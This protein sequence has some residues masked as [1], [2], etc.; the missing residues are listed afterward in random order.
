MKDKDIAVLLQKADEL[1]AL[2]TIGQRVIPFI[3]EIFVFVRDI[4]PLLDDINKSVA[5]NIKKMPGASEQLSKVNEANELAT[6][7]IMD[8]VD[9]LLFKVDIIAENVANISGNND[10]HLGNAI[11]LLDILYKAIDQNSNLKAILPQLGSS[12]NTLKNSGVANKEII[13]NNSDI[14]ES[15]RNDSNSIM[16]SLQVQDITSQQ[17]A[18]V[19]HMLITVQSKLSGILTHFQS[20]DLTTL[21]SG[22]NKNHGYEEHINV[23]K[24]HR[25]IAFDPIAVESL[26]RESARQENVDELIKQHLENESNV[27]N[28]SNNKLVIET[29]VVNEVDDDENFDIDAMFANNSD[30]SVD[31]VIESKIV[32]TLVANVDEDDDEDFDIDAMFANSSNNVTE[33][34]IETQVVETE[35]ANIE[36]NDDEDFDIDAMFANNP[37]QSTNNIVEDASKVEISINHQE[38]FESKLANLTSE[39]D[40]TD[41]F[42]QDDIDALF[43]KIN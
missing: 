26:N 17:L 32:E 29:Q 10:K 24:M 37:N 43:G 41:A 35:V 4:Q 3:E 16:M 33:K 7:E 19:N 18:A 2:F 28:E 15:I 1:R 13:R 42:S 34:V 20:S 11:K 36:K 6:T 9:G 40:D 22:D 23:T 5:E 12:I 21:V 38:D 30:K 14:L 25:D 39:G 8:I 31:N 27:S